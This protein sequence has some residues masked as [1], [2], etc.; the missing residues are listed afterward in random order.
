MKILVAEGNVA[1]VRERTKELCGFTPG[2]GY[3][4]V[5]RSIQAN[6]ECDILCPADFDDIPACSLKNYDGVVITGS[7]LSAYENVPA[8]T[9][10]IQFSKDV[11]E[12]GVP[13]FGSCWGLQIATVAAGGAVGPNHRG[14]EVGYARSVQ[15]TDAGKAHPMH[16]SRLAVF[17]APAVHTDHVTRLPAN[18]TVTAFNSMSEVQALEIRYRSGIFW[19]VQYHPEFSFLDIA[20]VIRRYGARLVDGERIFADM[21]D[22]ESYA[23]KMVDLHKDPTRKD[24]AWQYGLGADMTEVNTRLLEISNWL[25]HCQKVKSVSSL[26]Y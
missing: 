1:A 21:N 23:K 16:R 18:S 10:Q 14:R 3:A 19:G 9:R 6:I 5:L 26:P 7:A 12:S 8:V 22:L 13:F 20:T 17:D 24:I 4:D 15:L 2:E 25:Q 11:F